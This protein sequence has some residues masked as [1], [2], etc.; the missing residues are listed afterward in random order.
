MKITCVEQPAS[1]VSVSFTVKGPE[2]AYVWV[3]VA[4][5][6]VTGLLASPKSHT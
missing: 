4:L 2:L 3:V 1:S 5:A 6:V